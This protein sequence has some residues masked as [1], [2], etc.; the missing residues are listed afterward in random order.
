V[1]NKESNF[2][3]VAGGE[4]QQAYF[5]T[6]VSNNRNGN[7]DTIQTN[8]DLN[9]MTYNAFTQADWNIVES[10]NI[11]AGISLNRTKFEIKRLN[12]Y[13]VL[14]KEDNYKHELAPRLVI[15]KKITEDLFLKAT[16]SRGF[17]PPSM[18]EILPSTGVINTDLEAEYG[19]NYEVSSN[20]SLFNHKL[21][22][23]ASG[24]YFRLNNALVVRKDLAG[25][26]YFINAGDIKQKGVEITTDY[27]TAIPGSVFEYLSIQS[28]YT[29]N[30]FRYGS[31]IKDTF[32]FSGKKV[33]SV[34]SNSF[35]TLA[36]L[37]LKNGIYTNITYYTASKIYLNDA[38]TASAKGYDLLG[39]RLGWKKTW[40]NIR[41]INFYIGADNLLN[42]K[43]SLGNDINAPVPRYYNAAPERNYYVGL[44]FNLDSK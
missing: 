28:A 6:L 31:F 37:Q 30:H 14:R 15:R 7:P 40:Q 11:S 43:Y 3:L 4:F 18:M 10:W 9:F 36:D 44:S 29:Y 17:S 12:K 24:F 25:A 41:R 26:D 16:I 38:N 22:L 8:D 34:P 23:E 27:T 13:P 19:W 5:N 1:Y 33:P 39:I 2:Q 42:E 20:Y 35:S 21:R 32:N